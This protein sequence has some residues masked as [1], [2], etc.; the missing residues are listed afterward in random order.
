M[1]KDYKIHLFAVTTVVLWASTFAFTKIALEHFSPSSLGLLR[2]LVASV[3]LLV[4]ML[5]KKIPF[6]DF[7]DIPLFFLTGAFG[8]ALYTQTFNRG[9]AL[10]TGATASLVMASVPILTAVFASVFFREKIRPLGFAAFVVE[11]AGIAV[12]TL[13]NGVFAVNSGLFWIILASVSLTSYNLLQRKLTKKYT[14]L[15]CTAYSILA[16]TVLLLFALP[17]AVKELKTA[18]AKPILSFIYMGIFSSALAYVLWSLALSRARKTTDV[19]NYMFLSPVL[20]PVI[21]F[22]FA[23]EIP[24]LSDLAGGIIVLFGL[25]LFFR[26][27][28]EKEAV[29]S[30]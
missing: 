11:I 12:L 9:N 25:Y 10:L 19:T 14:A 27:N 30:T 2:Y 18:P 20:A 28:Q 17:G 24:A 3:T 6:P 7:R 13:W 1:K 5:I 21:S 8:F 29:K 23:G 4:V 15:Q 22:L 26:S 16:G